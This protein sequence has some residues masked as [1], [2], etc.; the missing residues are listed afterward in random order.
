MTENVLKKYVGIDV[1]KATLEVCIDGESKTVIF[2]NDIKEIKRL[3]K[4]LQSFNNVHVV[5]EATGGY[6]RQASYLMLEH[7]LFVS[8]VNARCVRDFAKSRNILA[9]TDKIDAYVIKEFGCSNNPKSMR[10]PTALEKKLLAL[11]NR[12]EQL[13]KLIKQEKQHIELVTK[14]IK[15][16][17]VSTIKHL[18]QQK[19]IIEEK[20]RSIIES[21]AELKEKTEIIS[22]MKGVGEVTTT[23]LLCDLPELGMLQNKEISALVGLAPFNR[24]SGMMKGKRTVYGGRAQI[25]AALYMCALSA[26]KFNPGIKGFYKRLIAKGKTKKVALIACAHKILI[27][28]NVLMKNKV[29]WNESYCCEI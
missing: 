2:N 11:K 18:G 12:R 4:K 21:D 26:S 28:L 3:I 19:E 27:I 20:I 6:E 8:V 16:N 25:R 29:R 14:D 23:I 10:S 17:I 9:K 15:K 1:S 22:S 5:M 13:V 7:G 24:D